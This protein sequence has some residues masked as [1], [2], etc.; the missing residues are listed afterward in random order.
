[1]QFRTIAMAAA[2]GLTVLALAAC[3][4]K[5]EPVDTAPEVEVT[6]S[7]APVVTPEETPAPAPAPAAAGDLTAPGTE[8]KV[9]DTATVEWDHF[10]LGI[11]QLNVTVDGVRTGTLAEL[12]AAGVSADT[13][14]KLDGYTP[15]YVDYTV[16]KANLGDG[17]LAY[18][19]ANEISAVNDK[20]ADIPELTLIGTYDLCDS[21]SFDT[22]VDEG[23]PQVECAIF[24]VP[25]GQNFGAATWTAYGTS[26]DKYDGQ[27]VYWWN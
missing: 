16:T 7:S 25:G 18:S 6:E 9:G 5:A 21:H 13:M 3:S 20:G 2:T 15:Y 14:A 23:T 10:E 1:M 22:S 19:S 12:E 11:V 17:E 8:L 26:Y 4:S 27:P 24:M